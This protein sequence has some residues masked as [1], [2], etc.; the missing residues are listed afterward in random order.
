MTK[1]TL[2][3]DTKF[4]LGDALTDEQVAFLDTYGFLHF[5]N[6]LSKD[7]V[8]TVNSSVDEVERKFIREDKKEIFGTP[9]F[10]GQHPD[11]T[12]RIQRLCFTSLFSPEVHD[13][14]SDPRFQPFLDYLG[15]DARVGEKEMD[16]VVVNGNINQPGSVY[17]RL[18]WHTDGLRDLFF[19]RMPQRMLNF[20]VHL[21]D[22]PRENGGLRLIPGSHTQGLFDMCF[23]KAYFV[24]HAADKNEIA[25]ETEAGDLT[26]HDGR[27]WHRVQQSSLTGEASRRRTMYVPFQTGPVIEKSEAS[28]TPLYHR[29]G[30]ALRSMSVRL[31]GKPGGVAG[32]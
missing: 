11:G 14:V 12:P 27:L 30:S 19:L 31:R 10:W 6:V 22:C 5:K 1:S 26:V 25:L 4:T 15:E 29:L 24:S 18:G 32:I 17:P 21:T 28:K 7:E 3:L 23:R 13:L 20:G 8:D 16:G 2:P 9:L